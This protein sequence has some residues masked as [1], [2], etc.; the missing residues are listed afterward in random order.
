MKNIKSVVFASSFGTLFEWYD[1]LIY[2][3]AA[4]LVFN[5][6]F[7]PNIDPVAGMLVALLTYAV[8]FF[9]RPFGG[10]FFGHFGDKY[11]RKSVLMATMVLMGFSTFA[12]GLLPTY[13]QIGLL[14]PIL[15]I[16][17][18]ILQGIGFGGEWGG[19]A[20]M[21]L[22]TCPKEKRGFYSSFIQVGFPL[23]LLLASGVFSLVS[24]LPKE[25]FMSWGWRIPF[26][27][28]ILLVAIGGYVRSKLA[29]TPVF[30]K[31]QSTDSV[32]RKPFFDIL[33]LY[34]KET[35]IAIGIKVTEVSWS[36]LVTV[37]LVAY[38]TTKLG[39]P[40]PML[41]E[42]ISLAA[43]INLFS[44]PFFGWVSDKIGRKPLFYI[45]GL[46]TIVM[47]FP[48][49]AIVNTGSSLA[50]TAVIVAGMV[51]G[52]AM[53][54]AGLAAYLAELFEP[55]VRYTGLSFSNQVAAAIGGGLAPTIAGALAAYFGGTTGVSIMMIIF[56]SITI[57]CTYLSKPRY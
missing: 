28:S 25:D 50:V 26:L 20:L 29:E 48:L 2:G 23:G 22:E 34:P 36:Y 17:L 37:F 5:T 43:L 42:A 3:T 35:L 13:D 12:I 24:M 10:A 49:F 9:A 55:N 18:R 41:L 14:A 32:S 54:F 47:A 4:A 27:L 30:K 1:F 57:I 39:M 33:F 51:F 21:I 45:G 38:A 52:N 6:L 56:A 11:G 19:A 46:F 15:L 7:F 40:K 16:V 31:L 8:G 53:M 44:I